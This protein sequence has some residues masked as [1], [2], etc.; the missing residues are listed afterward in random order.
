MVT[1]AV[2]IVKLDKGE[3][4]SCLSHNIYPPTSCR[5]RGSLPAWMLALFLLVYMC[6]A[7]RLARAC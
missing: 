2:S 5:L 1:W 7:S 3:D 4:V 6:L